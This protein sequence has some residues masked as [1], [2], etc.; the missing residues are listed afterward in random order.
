MTSPREGTPPSPPFRNQ[1]LWLKMKMMMTTMT[2]MMMMMMTMTMMMM[3]LMMMMCHTYASPLHLVP[4]HRPASTTAL[5][6]V[7]AFVFVFVFEFAFEFVFSGKRVLNLPVLA[8]TEQNSCR[9]PRSRVSCIPPVSPVSHVP[10]AFLSPPMCSPSRIRT[11]QPIFEL[12]PVFDSNKKS[13]ILF[14]PPLLFPL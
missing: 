14:C 10:P 4:I 6:F 2:T 3:L 12:M 11:L 7:F 13:P 9:L 5:V 8:N 1:T